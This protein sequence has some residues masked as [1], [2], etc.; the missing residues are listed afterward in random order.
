MATITEVEG[1]FDPVNQTSSLADTFR[2]PI[3]RP[4]TPSDWLAISWQDFKQVILTL[5]LADQYQL[6][7]STDGSTW[8]GQEPWPSPIRWWR[9]RF[10]LGQY[11]PPI[12]IMSGA[13]HLPWPVSNIAPDMPETGSGWFNPTDGELSVWSGT[14][15]L[16]IGPTI[17]PTPPPVVDTRLVG[18]VSTELV[19]TVVPPVSRGSAIWF[20]NSSYDLPSKTLTFTPTSH[21]PGSPQRFDAIYF[22]AGD[23]SEDFTGD[24]MMISSGSTVGPFVDFDGNPVTA[25]F[26]TSGR[27]LGVVWDYSGNFRLFEALPNRYADRDFTRYM[28]VKATDVLPTGAEF[29]VGDTSNADTMDVTS[30]PDTGFIFYATR[31]D[32]INFV[33]QEGSA[34][35]NLR[36][37]FRET[38]DSIVIAGDQFYVYRTFHAAGFIRYG[39]WVFRVEVDL[40]QP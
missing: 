2:I 29:L 40:A 24:S 38:P 3:G 8:R 27:L 35:N 18:T 23:V 32:N 31:Y 22:V 5:D 12:P 1:L 16:V 28:I 7:V 6:E 33:T 19:G 30:Q 4:G 21:T 9:F 14:A 17:T 25:F 37:I 15:W 26:V 13:A 10:G 34:D 39:Q 36:A 11:S 20:G